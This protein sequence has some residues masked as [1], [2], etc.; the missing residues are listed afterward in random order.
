VAHLRLC[1]RSTSVPDVSGP[2]GPQDATDRFSGGG[3]PL[4]GEG[5]RRPGVAH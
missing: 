4:D 1:E 5:L 2:N 3:G